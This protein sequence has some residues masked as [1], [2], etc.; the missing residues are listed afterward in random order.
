MVSPAEKGVALKKTEGIESLGKIDSSEPSV[1]A[2]LLRSGVRYYALIGFLALVVAWGIYAYSVQLRTGLV[3]TGMR[4]PVLWGL[5][6]SN[7]VFF[8]GISHAGTLISAIL[9][10]SGAEWRRPITRMAEAI[11]VMAI[12]VGALF[13]IIDLGRP[14]RIIN[15][16]TFGRIQSPIL[17]DFISIFTYLAGSFVYLYLPL[18]PDIGECRDSL[19]GASRLKRFLYSKL[20]LGWHGTDAQK[21]RLGKGIKAMAII[22]VPVAVS[23]HTV[24]SWIFAMTL[25]V[26]W[27]ST[28]LGPYFVTGA[29]FSG[30][31]S[32]IIVMAIFR[33][34]YHLEEYIKPMHF[35]NLGFLLLVLDL[36]LLYFTI[37]EYLTALYGGQSSEMTWMGLLF[38][39]SFSPYFW[40]MMVSAFIL[41]AI[42]IMAPWTRNIKGIVIAAILVDVGMWVE[43][44]LI[45]VPSLSVP[46]IPGAQGVQG[47]YTPT[48]VEWSITAAAFAGF[49]L[50][51]AI[52]SKIF[53]VVS[54]WEISEGLET[55]ERTD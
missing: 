40:A 34:M 30:I 35:R 29:I 7:F 23:V 19:T 51:F 45:V 33:R 15:V 47:L 12:S 20:A 28:M 31:A 44:F 48:W 54:H 36:A 42:L 53:P 1:F 26:G 3:V 6:I 9:R 52:F 8:I 5:Y 55:R 37:G 50:L 49:A 11:T 21:K 4:E 10:L 39:G 18:I 2:P 27:H 41:P 16:F 38:T 13:P 46:Q 32:I 17:W 14:D 24:V 22:I 25:R 43:R